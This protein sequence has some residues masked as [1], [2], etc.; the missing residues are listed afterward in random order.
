MKPIRSQMRATLLVLSALI[1]LA[2]WSAEPTPGAPPAGQP[3]PPAPLDAAARTAVVDAAA[4]AL[5]RRYVHPDV[6][7]RAAA[8]IKAALAAGSYDQITEN[9]AFA[10]RLTADIGAI[11]KD[12]H[13]RMNAQGPAPAAAQPPPAPPSAEGGVVRADRLPGNIGYIE[14][15]GFPPLEVFRAPVDKAM[16]TLADTRGLIID[17]RRNGGG[18]PISEVYLASYFLDPAKPV[19]VSRIIWRN[20]D[21]ETFRT[22]D[23]SNSAT[24]FHYAGKPVFVLTSQR[25]FSG[26][27]ALPYEMQVLKRVKVIG[28]V[29]G[30]G[31]NPGGTM[32]LG[33]GFSMFVPGGRNENPV[34]KT[35]WEGVGVQPDVVVKAEDALRVAL[36]ELGQTTDKS[37]IET[38]SEARLFEPRS[39]PRPGSEAAVR[40][41][42]A[43]LISGQPNYELMSSGLQAATRQ[44][45]PGMQ[46]MLR[47]LGE[48][49]SVTF[50]GI[51]GNGDRFELKFVNGTLNFMVLLDADGK[52]VMGAGMRRVATR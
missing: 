38:L 43:E 33:R 23:F 45:L 36:G 41:M 44:Q 28:E 32:P 2:A 14:I 3:G 11:A 46:D 20:P 52:I 48:L 13:L 30:G 37:T 1:G 19:I 10:D 5:T 12:K 9:R 8:S 4:D 25:T 49:Q 50:A 17:V 18:A 29:T 24:P 35:S 26:G 15:V 47:S 22:E 6:A 16:A 27:E 40:R 42:I 39:T 51:E 21:S 31:A 7:Q 34:T